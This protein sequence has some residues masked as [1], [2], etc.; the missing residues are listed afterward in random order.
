MLT[1]PIERTAQYS[2]Q[3]FELLGNVVDDPASFAV[4]ADSN[5]KDLAQI[6][7]FAKSNPGGLTVGTPGGGTPGHLAS[8]IFAKLTSTQFTHVPFKGA[9][10][11]HTALAGRHVT[12]AAI[13]V[14]EAFQAIK[15]G[16][17]VRV[18]AQLAPT[19]TTLVPDQLTAKEQGYAIE[20]SSLRGLA[21]PRGLAPEI[22]DRLIKAVAQAVADPEFQVKAHTHAHA[23]CGAQ[24]QSVE[25][26]CRG[27]L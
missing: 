9:G 15:G 21:A 6:V 25:C 3:R 7:A 19:R 8:T 5:I 14:G 2:W 4:H 16:R 26:S 24:H 18:L 22:R 27:D 13:S 20:M 17:A 23:H 1:I 11:V 10:D 12:L